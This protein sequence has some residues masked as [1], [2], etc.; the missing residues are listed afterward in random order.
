MKSESTSLTSSSTSSS[1]EDNP[2]QDVIV[3]FQATPTGPKCPFGN[4]SVEF[5]IVKGGC[6]YLKGNS[7]LGKTTL[8]TYVAGLSTLSSLQKLHIDVSQCEWSPSIPP[9]ERCGVLFQQTT[10]LDALTVAGNVCLALQACRTS[11]KLSLQ[12]RDFEIKRLLE[13]VG[14][15]YARDGPKR[16]SELSGG[17]A[18]RASLAL[19]LAQRKRLIILDEPFTGLDLAAATSVA[20]ELL[21]VRCHY[22]T[23]FILISHEP[24]LA[25]LIMDPTRTS[26]NVEVQLTEPTVSTTSSSSSSRF[27]TPNLFGIWTYQRFIEK[28]ADYVLWS[29]PLIAL[30]FVACGLAIAMLSSDILRR[31]DVTDQVLDIV[32]REVKPLLKMVTGEDDNV[33]ALM[34]VKMKVRSMMNTVIPQAKAHLYAIGMAKLFVLEIGPL[35]TALLLCGRIGGS[36]A[37]QIATLQATA[38][39]KL[40]RTLGIHPIVFTLV[41]SIFAALLAAPFLTVV[42]TILALVLGGMV[43]PKYGIGTLETYRTQVRSSIFPDLRLGSFMPVEEMGKD[44]MMS[45][46]S[47]TLREILETPLDL[48]FV[49]QQEASLQDT[50]VELLTYPP[51]FLW[52]KATTFIFIIVMTAE[53]TA[54]V[55]PNLTPRGVPGVI[56]SS[57]VIASLLVIVADWGFSQLWLLRI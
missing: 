14:L 1:V 57:V 44:G 22:G 2:N 46:R 12:E 31:I 33:M 7:G 36:Y 3:S 16:V 49:G 13:T 29:L 8:S 24:H 20:Q 18:R 50:L 54:R 32:D 23:A 26:H 25:K 6:L 4:A 5:E 42:G 38:Q 30:T 53:I 34:M 39:N 41:P 9:K 21:H 10:L 47:R 52:V 19:Q 55:R 40:L 48:R 15:D 35:L 51:I 43:G 11:Q 27:Q 17:M 56:T 37:G 45:S 28:L